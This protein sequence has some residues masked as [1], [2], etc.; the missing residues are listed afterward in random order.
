MRVPGRLSSEK[1]EAFIAAYETLKNTLSNDEEIYFT[2]AVHPQFQSQ[3]ACG[4]IK[5]GEVKTLPSTS[6]QYRLHF[7]GAVA[8]KNMEIFIQEYETVNAESVIEFFKKLEQTSDATI[9]HVICDNGPSYKNKKVQEYLKT[10]KVKIHYLPPYS[11]NLNPI[12]RLWKVLRE[13]K[14]Y[15]KCY[16]KFED[17]KAAIRNFLFE[18][19]PKMKN[20]LAKRINDKFQCIQLNTITIA[21]I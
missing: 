10:S 6:D 2:D 14:T 17:F 18:E 13:K 1:Q 11:P 9:L 21:S 8:L 12:E 16:E 3:T 20:E 15:N 19:I 4:W 5:K 7:V